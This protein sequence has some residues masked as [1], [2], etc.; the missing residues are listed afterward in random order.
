MVI[1]TGLATIITACGLRKVEKEQSES[2]QEQHS[3][4][5]KDSLHLEEQR[6]IRVL[7]QSRA[8]SSSSGYVMEIWPKGKFSLSNTGAFEGEAEKIKLQGKLVNTRKSF[9]LGQQDEAKSSLKSLNSK[10]AR[11]SKLGQKQVLL[12]KNPA[13]ARALLLLALAIG[14]NLGIH[15]W[16]KPNLEGQ[17]LF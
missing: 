8:D 5:S 13:W 1:V 10:V 16:K 4:I 2:L 7:L 3:E 9:Q 6:S 15:Y 14:I 11:E 17:H 12:K